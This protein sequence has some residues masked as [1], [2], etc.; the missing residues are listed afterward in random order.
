M[1]V[2]WSSGSPA[3]VVIVGGGFAALETLLALSAVAG[4]VTE[5]TLVAPESVLSYRPAA[6]AEAFGLMHARAWDLQEIADDLGVKYLRTVLEAVAGHQRR[7]RLRSGAR[8]S[9]D[10]LVLATGARAS[11]GIPGALTF[12]DQRD[13]RQFRGLVRELEAGAVRRLVFAVPAGRTWPLPLYELALM[14][15][16]LAEE[17]DLNVDV[18]LVTPE[19]SPLAVLGAEASELVAGVL[20]ER[21]VRFVGG[22]VAT[23]VG[24]DGSLARRFEPPIEADR[25]VACP[26]LRARRISGVPADRWGFVPTNALGVVDG[27]VGVYAA[28]DITTFPIKQGSLAAQQANRIAS[29]I[30]ASLGLT[31]G[32]PPAGRVVELM[33]VG[34][35][36]PLRLRVELDDLGQSAATALEPAESEV[37]A[38]WSKVF[39]RYLTSFL[40]A[41]PPLRPPVPAPESSEAFGKDGED[42]AP[43]VLR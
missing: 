5:L 11:A 29:A 36:R 7:V 10:A 41:R 37:E 12:R 18:S 38:S 26:Q 16:G 27:M 4:D 13:V 14:S 30:A 35:Q 20:D 39:G 22:A 33:L 2:D 24:R 6:T 1:T 43:G 40:E 17:R 3:R 34:G 25:V 15:A 32:E 28:G 8:L 21:G 9:Y 31:V 19:R 23:G 42:S